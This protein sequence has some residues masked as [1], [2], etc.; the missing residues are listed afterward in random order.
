[1]WKYFRSS[2]AYSIIQS[3][4]E[5]FLLYASCLV[6]GSALFIYYYP[7]YTIAMLA[8]TLGLSWRWWSSY[9]ARLSFQE[10]KKRHLE[11]IGKHPELASVYVPD[12]EKDIE[13]KIEKLKKDLEEKSQNQVLT[14]LESIEKMLHERII[15]KKN[16]LRDTLDTYITTNHLVLIEELKHQKEKLNQ[17]K[18]DEMKIVIKQTIKN[19]EEKKQI[20]EESKKELIFFYSQLRNI[21]QQLENMSL[22]SS[23]LEEDNQLFLELKQNVNE[24]F[25]GFSDANSLL[26]DISK[27]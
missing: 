25:E 2:S 11:L 13:N 17:N 27:L 8:A 1:M 3:M 24:A 12:F 19:L 6:L 9:Q 15:P 18:D 16:N 14:M 23:L 5:L 26:D 10:E 22:K 7:I 4:D 21:L 20:L